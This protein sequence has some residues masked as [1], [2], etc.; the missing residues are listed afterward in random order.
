M[1]EKKQTR[2]KVIKSA[3]RVSEIP[4]LVG[5]TDSA[6]IEDGDQPV[7]NIIAN[8]DTGAIIEVLCSCGKKIVLEC[9]YK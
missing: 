2:A 7:A 6:V 4:V 5:V 1:E 3:P 9:E 8:G